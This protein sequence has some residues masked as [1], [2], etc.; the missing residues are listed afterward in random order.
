[1]DNK[2]IFFEVLK[3]DF[4][5][6]LKEIGFEGSGQNIRRVKGEIINTINIQVNKYGGSCAVNLG[7]HLSF[8][9]LNWSESLPE[10]DKIKEIDCEF[11]KR[12]APENKSDYWWQYDNLSDSPS[13]RAQHLIETY[14]NYGEPHF[15]EYDTVEKIGAMVSVE[16]MKKSESLDI[17]GGVNQE[18][19]PLTMAR[20]HQHLGNSSKAK[21]F[22]T[23]GLENL[24]GAII[25][26]P[27]YEKILSAT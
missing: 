7:L 11:S 18:R 10:I 13:Q 21:A 26:K 14:F 16:E 12:L 25:L 3:E 23:F 27:E 22:A 1:M 19:G 2:K 24:N 15:Q 4:I 20:I 8:L 9:P 17:F 6:R 5:P